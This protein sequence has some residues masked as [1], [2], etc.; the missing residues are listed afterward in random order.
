[1]KSWRLIEELVSKHDKTV[2][3]V[4][5]DPLVA[6]RAHT[7]LHLEKGVLVEGVEGRARTSRGR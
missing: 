7:V 1:M 2:L 3:M 4:T 5:H 6:A